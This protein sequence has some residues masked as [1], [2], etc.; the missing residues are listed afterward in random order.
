MGMISVLSCLCKNGIY[1]QRVSWK[2]CQYCRGTQ[3]ES[4]ENLFSEMTN[5]IRSQLACKRISLAP[6]YHQSQKHINSRKKYSKGVL[7]RCTICRNVGHN[8]RNCKGF[9]LDRFSSCFLDNCRPANY[10]WCRDLLC[11]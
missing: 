11:F 4:H 8:D 7:K 1:Q 5:K 6:T 3:Q 2:N 9:Q 10:F